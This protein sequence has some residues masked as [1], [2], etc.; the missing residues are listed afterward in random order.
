MAENL[1]N[2]SRASIAALLIGRFFG[3]RESEAIAF[4]VTWFGH[5]FIAIRQVCQITSNIKL[6]ILLLLNI[7]IY[8]WWSW[9]LNI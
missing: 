8:I 5:G 4:H 2:P 9:Q 6:L 7:Y 3:A 1:T